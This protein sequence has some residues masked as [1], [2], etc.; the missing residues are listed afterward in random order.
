M[1]NKASVR[2]RGAVRLDL[3]GP[4]LAGV[5]DWRRSQPEI[6]PRSEAVRVLL[7]LA[8]SARP[9][10]GDRT[11]FTDTSSRDADSPSARTPRPRPPEMRRPSVPSRVTTNSTQKS[12]IVPAMSP[13]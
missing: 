6:P 8:L 4:I 10:G 2:K 5:E 9:N 3:D 12:E 7:T 1:L 13:T 11:T